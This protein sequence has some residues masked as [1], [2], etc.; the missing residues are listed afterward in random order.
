M[1]DDQGKWENTA[2]KEK[3][4]NNKTAII[5]SENQTVETELPA[6]IQ[7]DWTYE[8]VR[9]VWKG[10]IFWRRKLRRYSG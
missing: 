2:T 1:E 9:T 5:F 8:S 6:E 3:G 7:N 10:G 4:K